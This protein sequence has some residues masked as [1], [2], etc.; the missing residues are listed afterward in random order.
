ML[1]INALYFKGEW[2]A[3]FKKEQSFHG[4]FYTTPNDIIDVEYMRNTGSYH[5]YE[6]KPLDAQL[7]RMPFKVKL[8]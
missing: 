4:G 2:N 3:Q 1:V 8:H 5:Y 7:L 6:S